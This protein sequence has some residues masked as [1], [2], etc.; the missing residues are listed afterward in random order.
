MIDR[1]L[2]EGDKVYIE[3]DKGE[4]YGLV[5]GMAT[6]LAVLDDGDYLVEVECYLSHFTISEADIK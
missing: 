3:V 4:D 2:E 5:S 6:I 1:V